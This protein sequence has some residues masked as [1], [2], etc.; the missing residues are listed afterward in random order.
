MK[1]HSDLIIWLVP[2]LLAVLAGVLYNNGEASE[3]VTASL[4]SLA[5]AM[6][7]V[8]RPR[9]YRDVATY[10]PNVVAR[11]EMPRDGFPV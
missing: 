10:D 7:N 8:Y 5:T 1:K 11:T 6:R 9:V 2:V 4:L 3:C